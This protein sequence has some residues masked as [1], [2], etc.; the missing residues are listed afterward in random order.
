MKYL[1]LALLCACGGRE[2]PMLEAGTYDITGTYTRDDWPG[3]EVGSTFENKIT[4]KV[5]EGESPRWDV[6]HLEVEGSSTEVDG[7]PDG[8]TIYFVTASFDDRCGTFDTWFDTTLVPKN[9]R[10]FSGSSNSGISLCNV[11][12]D[13]VCS[14]G[15]LWFSVSLVGKLDE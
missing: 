15:E 14:C 7:V 2:S 8:D 11:S 13:G 4:L 1:L 3:G 12:A 6:Y 10:S 9:H 5:H